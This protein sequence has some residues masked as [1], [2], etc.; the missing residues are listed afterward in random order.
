[1]LSER[2]PEANDSTVA[3]HWDDDLVVGSGSGSAM[4]TLIERRTRFVVLVQLPIG[5]SSTELHD[6]PGGH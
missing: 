1:M 5:H 6:G 2:F 3:G 4:A